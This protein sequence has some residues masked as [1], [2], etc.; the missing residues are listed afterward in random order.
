MEHRWNADF[1]LFR[2]QA[3]FGAENSHGLKNSRTSEIS[4][5]PNATVIDSPVLTRILRVAEE[6]RPLIALIVVDVLEHVNQ[7][8]VRLALLLGS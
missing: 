7:G 6:A 2:F 1:W 4:Y 3:A 5:K 8:P